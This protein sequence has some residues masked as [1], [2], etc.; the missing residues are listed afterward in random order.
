MRFVGTAIVLAFAA[1][2]ALGGQIATREP[3]AGSA[4]CQGCHSDIHSRWSDTIHGKMIQVAARASVLASPAGL[5]GGPDSKFW[6][7][8]RF[9][10]TDERGRERRIEYTLG[11]RRIQHYLTLDPNGAITLLTSAWD[12]RRKQWF[13]SSEIVPDAPRNLVQ[14]WNM[15]CFFCHVTQQEQDV[16]GFDPGSRTYQTKWVESS[17]TCE[18]CH[19]PMAAHVDGAL[20]NASKVERSKAEASFERLMICGQCHWPKTVMATGFTTNK[21]YLDHYAPVLI[22]N[23]LDTPG[24]PSGWADGRPKRFSTEARGFFMSGCYQSGQATCMSCHDPHWNRTD[25]NEQLMTKPDQYC[26]N[27]HAGLDKTSHTNHP[28]SSAGSSCVGCHMPKTVSGVKDRMRDHT[29]IAPVPENT[30]DY[31]IPNACNECHTDRSSQWAVEKME[32]WYPARSAKPRLRALAFSLAKRG[33]PKAVAPL[34]RLVSDTAEN[35]IVRASAAGFLA[36]F[37]GPIST[38]VLPRLGN[39]ADPFVRM[40]TARALGKV[41]GPGNV[42]ALASLVQDRYRVVRIQAAAALVRLAFSRGAPSLA[43]GH[44]AFPAFESAVAE[45]RSSL[46]VERDLPEVLVELGF[47]ELFAGQT[48]AASKA[49]RQAA[50]LDNKN[51]DAFYGLALAE[52]A[53]GKREE[54]VRNAR[55]AFELSGKEP[56][57]QLRDRLAR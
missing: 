6:R 48:E 9:Y 51:A 37:P 17:A 55:R 4:A 38:G 49:Y 44:P 10:I 56:H 24:D 36:A 33:D 18:R 21:S 2:F 11:N 8:G 30:I 29:M 43:R 35:P 14:Q 3:V 42:D 45:Y 39:D 46:E 41:D 20:S 31:A 13:H 53:Q 34:L 27:C 50:E 15:T 47:L 25:G 1:L 22:H 57:R 7:D 52:L 40:E 23:D 26:M 5:P 16:K 12:V 54:A 32:S 19:G 28:P